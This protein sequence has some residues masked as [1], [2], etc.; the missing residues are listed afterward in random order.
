MGIGNGKNIPGHLKTR[1][2][3]YIYDRKYN[4]TPLIAMQQANRGMK[5][6]GWNSGTQ[7][8]FR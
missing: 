2:Y 5:G 4:D 6:S 7:K 3:K 1:S 8:Q